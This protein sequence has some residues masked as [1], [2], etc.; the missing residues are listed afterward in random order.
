MAP[1]DT[2]PTL[3]LYVY[4]DDTFMPLIRMIRPHH[5]VQYLDAVIT[6]PKA[7]FKVHL[8]IVCERSSYFKGAFFGKFKVNRLHNILMSNDSVGGA[9]EK[10]RTPRAPS[11]G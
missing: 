3:S 5:L 1:G 7:S 10:D 6:C 4:L 8:I 2:K 11:F 9:D